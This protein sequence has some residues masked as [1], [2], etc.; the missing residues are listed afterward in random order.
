MRIVKIRSFVLGGLV[1]DRATPKLI[2]IANCQGITVESLV[3]KMPKAYA[4]QEGM[5]IDKLSLVEVKAGLAKMILRPVC[6]LMNQ[7]EEIK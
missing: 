7:R 4:V 6:S 3:K 2:R 5:V 1:V